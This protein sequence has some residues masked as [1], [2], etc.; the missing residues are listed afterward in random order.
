MG[1]VCLLYLVPW[2]RLH[3]AF[4][5]RGGLDLFALLGIFE[6]GINAMSRWRLELE[7]HGLRQEDRLWSSSD[8][9]VAIH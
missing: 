5:H 8:M 2:L 7:D 1:L 3:G 9:L 6:Q 4:L